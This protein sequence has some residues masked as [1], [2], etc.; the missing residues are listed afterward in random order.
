MSTPCHGGQT[1]EETKEKKSRFSPSNFIRRLFHSTVFVKSF[2]SHKDY[3][4]SKSTTPI[5]VSFV[6]TIKLFLFPHFIMTITGTATTNTTTERGE[7]Q[8]ITGTITSSEVADVLGNDTGNSNDN[9]TGATTNNNNNSKNKSPKKRFI[10]EHKKPDAALT[11]PEK[12]SHLSI[13]FVVSVSLDLSLSH[14]HSSQCLS[15]NSIFLSDVA[16][17]GIDEIC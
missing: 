14:S 10:P 11:F 16:A 12:V 8:D 9:D 6:I 13:W 7:D 17:H 2:Y 15:Q 3:K 1:N 5:P 4:V